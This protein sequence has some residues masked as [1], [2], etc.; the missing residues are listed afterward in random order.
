[1]DSLK[2]I[3]QNIKKIWIIKILFLSLQ[4]QKQ[5]N[6]MEEEY[7]TLPQH[8]KDILDTY[9][10][11]TELYSECRRMV[12]ELEAIG[13]TAEFDLSGSLYDIKKITNK[14]DI[15][16]IV[17]EGVDEIFNTVSDKYK[18]EYGD[19]SPEEVMKLKEI[20]KQLSVLVHGYVKNNF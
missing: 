8:I 14:D 7:D 1:V 20:K 11:N 2:F 10:E 6:I 4:S 16:D 13:W 12:A 18:L 9:D 5:L 15:A 17:S 19:V 3:T